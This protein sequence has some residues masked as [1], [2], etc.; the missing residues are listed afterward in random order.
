MIWYVILKAIVSVVDK[1]F[2]SPT[3]GG[4]DGVLDNALQDVIRDI[5]LPESDENGEIDGLVLL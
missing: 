3:D 4:F 2:I 5:H 1:E